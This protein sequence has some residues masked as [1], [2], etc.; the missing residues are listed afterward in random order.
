MQTPPSHGSSRNLGA[1][2]RGKAQGNTPN[3]ADIEDE[4]PISNVVA[5]PVTYGYVYLYRSEDRSLLSLEEMEDTSLFFKI[6]GPPQDLP[7]V[8]NLLEKKYPY[9][10]CMS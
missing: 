8:L 4:P 6:K 10:K 2:I 9:T 7:V 3:I 1:I 5:R